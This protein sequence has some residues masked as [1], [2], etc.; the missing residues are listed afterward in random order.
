[1]GRGD[2]RG[3]KLEP[4]LHA[5]V[6]IGRV[7]LWSAV[8]MATLVMVERDSGRKLR[9]LMENNSRKAKKKIDEI[10]EVHG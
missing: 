9:E 5:L 1:M 8:V 4:N 2:W 7:L 3:H 6:S 10:N